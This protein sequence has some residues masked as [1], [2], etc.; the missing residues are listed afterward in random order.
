MAINQREVY[1][2]PFPFGGNDVEPHPFIILSVKE[3]NELE[4]TVIAVM[5]TT[6]T[7]YKDDYSFELNDS[8]F[9]RPLPKPNSHVRMHLVTVF[10]KKEIKSS[11][12]GIMNVF[13]FNQLMAS[14]GELVFGYTMK[15]LP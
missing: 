14:I 2:F 13:F 4:N 3:A 1:K 7:H 11:R 8:M 9:D 10:L 15:K 6:S 12:I 5:I